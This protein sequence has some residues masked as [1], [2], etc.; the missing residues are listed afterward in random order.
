ML[1]KAWN[2]IPNGTFMNCFKNSRISQ[3]QMEKALNGK[4]DL[5]GSLDFE[6][7]VMESLKYDLEVMKEKLHGNFGKLCKQ[8]QKN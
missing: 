3:K 1:P 5:F 4:D 7:D 2:S 6:E 8:Q